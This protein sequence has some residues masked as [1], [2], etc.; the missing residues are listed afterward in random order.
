MPGVYVQFN[1]LAG[2]AGVQQP[3]GRCVKQRQ[4]YSGLW[5][6]LLGGATRPRMQMETQEL[7]HPGKE[8]GDTQHAE[9]LPR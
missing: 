2:S 3:D 4:V 9:T 5:A 7:E 6:Q 8:C 1:L